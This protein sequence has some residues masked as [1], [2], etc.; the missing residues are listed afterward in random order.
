MGDPLWIALASLSAVV[1]TA[2]A[3]AVYFCYRRFFYRRYPGWMQRVSSWSYGP[4]LEVTL[5]PSGVSGCWC[6]PPTGAGDRAAWL[7]PA[8][9][10][11]PARLFRRGIP[12]VLIGQ[13]AFTDAHGTKFSFKPDESAETR[14]LLRQ[15]PADHDR[16]PVTVTVAVRG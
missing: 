1:F 13:S 15:D 6:P 9:A 4:A 11:L 7:Q 8:D 16:H 2:A 5:A 10:C 14:H 3:V 12:G